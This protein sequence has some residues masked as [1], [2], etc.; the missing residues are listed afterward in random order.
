MEL[1]FE[2]K[3]KESNYIA[4]RYGLSFKCA[5]DSD[6]DWYPRFGIE[7]EIKE[8]YGAS[9]K[10]LAKRAGIKMKKES[11]KQ[12]ESKESVSSEESESGS[13][14]SSEESEE[15][16]GENKA[17]ESDEESEESEQNWRKKDYLDE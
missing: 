14:E 6:S 3:Q 17:E 9:S 1:D 7:R 15:Y 11:N 13:E 4:N 12:E 8:E 5:M 10:E 16:H 2:V